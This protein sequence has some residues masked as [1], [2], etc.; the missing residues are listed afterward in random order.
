MKNVIITVLAILV[1]CLGGYLVYDK[2]II[3]DN[4]KIV[5]ENNNINNEEKI[6][7]SKSEAM[8]LVS[9]YI[10]G[11]SGNT[12]LHLGMTE[13]VM[14][15]STLN[16]IEYKD[17]SNYSCSYLEQYNNINENTITFEDGNGFDFYCD[18]SLNYFSYDALNKIYKEYYGKDKE[19]PKRN[20]ST[21]NN[22]YAYV[23]TK[24][25]KG[26]IYLV[27]GFGPS[28]A[29]YYGIKSISS[30]ENNLKI[31]VGYASIE[32]EMGCDDC[33]CIPDFDENLRF[34]YD[35]VRADNFGQKLVDDYGDKMK[36]VEFVFEKE[37]NHYILKSVNKQ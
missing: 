13:D 20:F 1:L 35:E 29:D 10:N 11:L 17:T 6:E 34:T 2:V 25:E 37:D 8:D 22:M 7:I 5:D 28:T 18:N 24:D 23:L 9:K 12:I 32:Y 4:N 14:M 33:R 19:M 30:T 15:Q 26:Y 31:M 16:K 36:S 21:N 3:K 27:T